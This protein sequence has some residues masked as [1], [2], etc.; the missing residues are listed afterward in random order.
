M[1]NAKD[2]SEDFNDY[3]M[4]VEDVDKDCFKKFRKD[5]PK[6]PT[7]GKL[8]SRRRDLRKMKI[9]WTGFPYDVS[10]K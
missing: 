2:S 8:K 3:S 4:G 9:Q 5:Y 1:L 7:V 6:D 10:F